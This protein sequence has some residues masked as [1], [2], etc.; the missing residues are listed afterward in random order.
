MARFGN[1]RVL[2]V[3]DHDIVRIGLWAAI[4]KKHTVV[5]HAPNGAEALER[6]RQ[7]RPDVVVADLRLP[8]MPGEELCRRIRETD[9][10]V[11]VVI[12]S[13]YLSEE[14]V[15]LSLDAGAA[16]Y[17]TKAA[18]LPELMSV[19][20]RLRHNATSARPESAPQIVARLHAV[21]AGRTEAVPLTPTQASILEL[22][23]QGLTNNQIS[24]RL[25]IS[26]STVRFHIQ[27]M[28]KKLGAR[29]KT[30]LVV[31]AMRLGAIAPG[32][33]SVRSA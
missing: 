28:K 26:E 1:I 32:P 29:S 27:N 10:M 9:P 3:D 2:L 13:A 8:D 31:R 15:R 19:L 25:F 7:T 17:V 16:A 12:L 24:G 20:E 22:A 30:D 23:A 21:V 33:E 6:V 18:G 11:S 4:S 14:T 5:G